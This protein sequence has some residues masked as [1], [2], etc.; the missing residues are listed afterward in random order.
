MAFKPSDFF[1]NVATIRIHATSLSTSAGFDFDIGSCQQ[2]PGPQHQFFMVITRHLRCHGHD[3]CQRLFDRMAQL[4]Q[5]I[6]G[7]SAFFPAKFL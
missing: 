6:R 2:F 5:F 7:R 1:V 3:F 4:T